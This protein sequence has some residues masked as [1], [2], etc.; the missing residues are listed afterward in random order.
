MRIFNVILLALVATLTTT[1][2]ASAGDLAFGSDEYRSGLNVGLSEPAARDALLTGF[3]VTL[4]GKVEKDAHAMGFDVDIDGP[5]GQ[6]LYAAGFSVKVAQPVGEDA[7]ISGAT[8][9]LG[10]DAAIGGNARLVGAD[11]VID[12]PISGNLLAAAGDL[13]INAPITGDAMITARTLTFGAG[14]RISGTLTY[15]APAAVAIAASVVAP[16]RV[17]FTK[18]EA[19]GQV[20]TVKQ[21]IDQSTAHLW[22]SLFA[23]L[24]G[25]IVS[26]L[27]LVGI[28]ALL[29]VLVPGKVDALRAM[30]LDGA[31]KSIAFG[32]LGLSMLIG[33]IPISIMAIIGIPLVPVILLLIIAFW[34]C[35]YLLGVHALAMSFANAFSTPSTALAWRLSVLAAGLCVLALLNF[36]PFIGWLAN[37]LTV[38]LGM[39]GITRAVLRRWMV[40]ADRPGQARAVAEPSSGL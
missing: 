31:G 18:T 11:I 4:S 8:I 35:G 26:L 9:R 24:V 30:T 38:L 13:T 34:I 1:L 22:P 2:P 28:G 20:D 25:V 7:T 5:V 33:L 39:G 3:S 32:I 27:F 37:L 12:A 40:Q 23:V 14:A 29:L 21:A 19:S 16:E 6:D 17:H 36:I 15:S 10:K